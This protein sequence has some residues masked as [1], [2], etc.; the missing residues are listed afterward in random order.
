MRV[1]QP[2]GWQVAAPTWSAS[3]R[4][5]LTPRPGLPG[6]PFGPAP[7]RGSRGSPGGGEPE[8]GWARVPVRA[9]PSPLRSRVPTA[10]LEAAAPGSHRGQGATG[11]KGDSPNATSAS[12][13]PPP[14]PAPA[15]SLA[16]ASGLW[17]WTPCARG[18]GARGMRAAGGPGG[19]WG[20]GPRGAGG[21]DCEVRGGAGG[22]R[23][24]GGGGCGGRGG[25]RGA[26][27]PRG[28]RGCGLLC[29]RPAVAAR[30]GRHARYVEGDSCR[31]AAAGPEGNSLPMTA[32][33]RLGQLSRLRA[34]GV[35]G[36]PGGCGCCHSAV[37]ARGWGGGGKRLSGRVWPQRK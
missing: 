21:C 24:R 28:A 29:P 12:C 7:G 8:P 35:P 2:G 33:A 9:P 4:G 32:G 25:Y 27:R 30:A 14:A 15:L 17:A 3:R 13:R 1:T 18:S 6:K 22:L 23:G 16:L 26:P 34:P 31:V 19:A 20:E 36:S 10:P 5:D 37:T 11:P